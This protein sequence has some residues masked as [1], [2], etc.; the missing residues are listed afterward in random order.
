MSYA[1]Q[2]YFKILYNNKNITEDISACLRSITYV[3]NT[4]GE[5]DEFTI[6]VDD[7]DGRWKGPWFPSKG[8]KLTAE[9]G[10]LGGSVL[11]CGTFTVDEFDASG[12]PDIFVIKALAA[13][14]AKAVRTKNTYAH[15]NKN[16]RQ[17]VQTVAQNHGFEV[18]GDIPDIQIGYVLQ[19][20]ETDLSFLY[21]LSN[22]YGCTFNL[23]DNKLV[24]TNSEQLEATSAVLTLK[25]EDV[26]PYS[27]NDKTLGT[28]AGTDVKHYSQ[29]NNEVVTGSAND[30]DFDSE[31]VET[32][33]VPAENSQQAEV[34]ARAALNKSNSRE[35]TGSFTTEGNTLI[36]A[37]N[38]VNMLGWGQFD[39]LYHIET[40][41]HTITKADGYKTDGTIKMGGTSK[42]ITSS[43]K[44]FTKKA[45]A[46]SGQDSFN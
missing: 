30:D 5:A 32:I 24:F 2:P 16:L 37:G 10:M 43:T 46:D 21:R 9:I 4:A 20:K 14:T 26:F 27:F 3:D 11:K 12:P 42:K 22:D 29:K 31:D 41:T 36:I 17:I 38:N 15:D 28:F 25:K 1:P 23:R 13:G 7:V 45:A 40:S 33:R 44:A 18:L 19:N 34:K 39:G 6:E 8:A 35:R